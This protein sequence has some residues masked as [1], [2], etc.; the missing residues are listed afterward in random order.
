[1]VKRAME[2]EQTKGSGSCTLRGAEAA[3]VG[4]WGGGGAAFALRLQKGGAAWIPEGE[5]RSGWRKQ[6][7][8]GGDEHGDSVEARGEGRTNLD[9]T[10]T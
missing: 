5:E 2:N 4:G 10:G 8:H 9:Q 3:G 6:P 7:A 1:M